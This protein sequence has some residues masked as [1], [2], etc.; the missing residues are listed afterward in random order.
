MGLHTFIGMLGYCERAAG[1]LGW[2]WRSLCM[3]EA[4]H[5]A[6]LMQTCA[7]L[8][9]AAVPFPPCPISGTKDEG[10]PHFKV[11]GRGVA[12]W[13]GRTVWVA[14]AGAVGAQGAQELYCSCAAA[15]PLCCRLSCSCR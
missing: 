2:G 6:A 4:C 8:S 9:H 15:R 13:L 10:Q 1:G 14:A 12:L 7:A 5:G 11:R 3:H